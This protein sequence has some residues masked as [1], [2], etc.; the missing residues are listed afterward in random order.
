MSNSNEQFVFD[1]LWEGSYFLNS[2]SK[3]GKIQ[4]QRKTDP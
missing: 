2:S 4:L 1:A 3:I